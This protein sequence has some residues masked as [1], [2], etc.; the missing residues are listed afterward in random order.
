VGD[1]EALRGKDDFGVIVK[2][3]LRVYQSKA[4]F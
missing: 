2:V 1:E 3:E 4:D